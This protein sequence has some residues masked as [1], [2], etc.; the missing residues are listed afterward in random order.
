MAENLPYSS[1]R[2][3]EERYDI[4]SQ[5]LHVD[6][7]REYFRFESS[8]GLNVASKYTYLKGSIDRLKK[9]VSVMEQGFRTGSDLLNYSKIIDLAEKRIV[10]MRKCDRKEL[11]KIECEKMLRPLDP[12][13]RAK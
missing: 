8:V 12:N 3:L 1:F 2:C 13:R 4:Y 11:T 9:F 6:F 10:V 7:M 5:E